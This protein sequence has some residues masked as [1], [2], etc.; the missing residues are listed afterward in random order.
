MVFMHNLQPW[1]LN[2][3]PW[4]VGFVSGSTPEGHS[5]NTHASE[6]GTQANQPPAAARQPS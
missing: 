6:E 2:D 1:I 3:Q 5:S 4:D